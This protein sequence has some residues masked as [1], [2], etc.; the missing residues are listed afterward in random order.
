MHEV[1]YSIKIF[2][3]Y[4][5]AVD[6]IFP[7]YLPVLPGLLLS[8]HSPVLGGGW[9]GFTSPLECFRTSGP[10]LHS[11]LPILSWISLPWLLFK[12]LTVIDNAHPITAFGYTVMK[13][14][15]GHFPWQCCVH[16]S[17]KFRGVSF[18]PG[19][20]ELVAVTQLIADNLQ[21]WNRL[22]MCWH[23]EDR[24][25]PLLVSNSS[26]EQCPDPGSATLEHTMLPALSVSSWEPHIVPHT[27]LKNR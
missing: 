23:P 10:L 25:S 18:G 3:Q 7:W 11:F 12:C 5:V 24:G 16:L 8:C 26:H 1:S 22:G 2:W 19:F 21:G 6:A 13:I 9:H 4:K 15:K 17:L 20:T 27:F 14:S